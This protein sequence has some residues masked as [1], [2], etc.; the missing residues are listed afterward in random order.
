MR[1][2][3]IFVYL[4]KLIALTV[5][6][7]FI[8]IMNDSQNTKKGDHKRFVTLLYLSMKM[9]DSLK[10]SST[11]VNE[12]SCWFSGVDEPLKF[13]KLRKNIT[14]DIAIVG[15]SIAGLSAAYN[16]SKADK[17]VAVLEDGYIGSGETGHTTAHLT[18][19]LDDR[20][21]NLEKLFGIDGAVLA[22]ESHT[23]A[24]NFIESVV[25]EENIE[26]DFERLNGYL[27]LSSR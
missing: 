5:A 8:H 3:R 21:F 2:D 16:L 12:L 4:A 19:A 22:A 11:N 13:D 18:N 26:C 15:G 17:S 10:G 23:T 24:I 20:Y 1:A 27:F 6:L 7:S 14:I 25:E 9:V